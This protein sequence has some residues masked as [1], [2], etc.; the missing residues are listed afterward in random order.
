MYLFRVCFDFDY[1]RWNGT[2]CETACERKARK[3]ETKNRKFHTH[4]SFV[5]FVMRV[6][7]VWECKHFCC[8]VEE[9]LLGEGCFEIDVALG[10]VYCRRL[11]TTNL[12][13]RGTSP[14]RQTHI[15]LQAN[16]RETTNDG[17]K[18]HRHM[19]TNMNASPIRNRLIVL[20][21]GIDYTN[22][23]V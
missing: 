11:C 18:T 9:I 15:H 17:T 14:H 16:R 12:V 5:R 3:W 6:Y 10:S 23:N 22:E 7:T 4:N 21:Y 13:L 1:G 2:A 19:H 20:A 8:T